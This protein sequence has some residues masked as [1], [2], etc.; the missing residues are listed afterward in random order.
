MRLLKT[1]HISPRCREFSHCITP[2][3]LST[4]PKPLQLREITDNAMIKKE[5]RQNMGLNEGGRALKQPQQAMTYGYQQRGEGDENER[6]P[7]GIEHKHHQKQSLA[8]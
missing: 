7:Q 3:R 2:L 5:Q 1:N 4:S 6:S 8:F